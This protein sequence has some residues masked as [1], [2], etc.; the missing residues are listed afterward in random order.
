MRD[1]RKL[2][3]NHCKIREWEMSVFYRCRSISRN[4]LVLGVH[5]FFYNL[6]SNGRIFFTKHRVLFSI[7]QPFLISEVNFILKQAFLHSLEYTL[8]YIALIC[9]Y[10]LSLL[11]PLPLKLDWSSH[12]NLSYKILIYSTGCG[13]LKRLTNAQSHS[14]SIVSSFH[15]LAHTHKGQTRQLKAN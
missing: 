3:L 6:T 4:I 2:L 13:K 14:F 5:F 8:Y 9:V 11:V 12:W 15:S 1:I 7:L 10:C